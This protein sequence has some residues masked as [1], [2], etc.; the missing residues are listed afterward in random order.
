MP[1][2]RCSTTSEY[3]SMTVTPEQAMR[4]IGE[5]TSPLE[6][7]LTFLIHATALRA[8]EALGL[9]WR[10]IDFQAGQIN[11]RRKWAGGEV[12][13][14]K[15]KASK[16]AVALTKRLAAV[17]LAWKHESPYSQPDDWVFAS[18]A[19]HGR[20][21]RLVG[22]I[23]KDYLRPAAIRAGVLQRD[24]KRTFG[25]HVLRHS[26]ATELIRR[27]EDPK[28]VQGVLRHAQVTTTLGIYAHSVPDAQ[29]KAQERF[30]KP[31]TRVH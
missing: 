3:E 5:I 15:T 30:L 25:F 28:L 22:M 18:F 13:E 19:K 23:V 11:V 20:Q 9:Q 7:T 8:S 2:V 12:G 27:K 10:D 26:H 29:K 31:S 16:A 4:I 17:L 6:R 14:P 24:D 1:L 21:P